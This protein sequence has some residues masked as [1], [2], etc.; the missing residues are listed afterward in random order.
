MYGISP[1]G[2]TE[3]DNSGILHLSGAG[4]G[5]RQRQSTP[6]PHPAPLPCASAP[7]RENPHP[8][9]EP[10][11][12]PKFQDSSFKSHWGGAS[13]PRATGESQVSRLR[14]VLVLLL[15]LVLE[16][17]NPLNSRQSFS[18]SSTSTALRAEYEYEYEANPA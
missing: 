12:S 1:S 11:E 8:H 4:F 18:R 6:S 5:E 14:D 10:L 7:L 9:H 16:P 17:M 3:A 15:V 13:V 2:A